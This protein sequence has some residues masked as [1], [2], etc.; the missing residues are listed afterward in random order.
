[1]VS[2][3]SSILRMIYRSIPQEIL[4][5]TF[6]PSDYQTTLDRRIQDVIINGQVLP[7]LNINSGKIK[8]IP[9]SACMI[10]HVLPDPGFSSL[11][12][13]TP[14]SLYRI[15]AEAREN[16]DIVGVIDISY[17][18]DYGGMNDS[19]FGLGSNGN[20]VR[21]MANAAINSHTGRNACLT[22]TPTLQPDNMVLINPTNSFI[23][24]WCLVCRLGFDEE[25][26][27]INNG[28][29][30]P[31]SKLATTATKAYIWTNLTI[32]I[33]QAM[34]SGGQELGRFKDVVD[35][36]ESEIERYEEDLHK[37]RAAALFDTDA[38][39][40]FLRLMV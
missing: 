30:L 7:D 13:P 17:L 22:P 20:T 37:T 36:Y 26:T 32:R 23:S 34:L 8:R 35:K 28:A 2:A 25:F 12:S 4:E 15:P 24:D 1:M 18:Y 11:L 31:L 6:R 38:V 21:S 3:F 19:P 27:N 33:D 40:Y 29:I 10:E 39:R 9:L 5:A 14:G 16:R